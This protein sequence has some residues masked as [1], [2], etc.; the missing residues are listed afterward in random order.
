MI[1]NIQYRMCI[2]SFTQKFRSKKYL[3]LGGNYYKKYGA[4]QKS[5]QYDQDSVALD[6]VCW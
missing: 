4:E 1:D 2:G 5:G 3:Y 6:I